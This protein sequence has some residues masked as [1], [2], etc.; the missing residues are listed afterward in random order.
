MRSKQTVALVE[1]AI[2]VAIAFVLSYLKV[3]LPQGGSVTAVSMLPLLLIGYRRGLTWG[4]S[5]G[6]VYGF[7]QI[8]QHG[9]LSSPAKELQSFLLEL[10]LDYLIAFA[11]LGLSALFRKLKYGLP[12][13]VPVCLGL[14][15]FCHFLSG[16]VVWGSYT[17]EG[18]NVAWYSFLYNG[19][20]MGL[21]I[22]ITLAVVLLLMKA[23]PKLMRIPESA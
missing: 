8:L 18:M 3:S 11:V 2:L 17:P 22:I 14:R 12:I 23:T 1:S 5:S 7:L 6:V 19:S 15:F 16:I 13:C 9:G 20:Y 21:E 10:L 4:V